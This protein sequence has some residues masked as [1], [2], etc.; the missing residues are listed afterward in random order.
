[1]STLVAFFSRSGHTRDLAGILAERLSADL[2]T[3]T[4]L[5][6]SRLGRRGYLRSSVDAILQNA[7]AIRAP[8]HDP[9]SYDLVIIGTPVWWMGVSPPVRT[10]LLTHRGRLRDVAFFG[11]CG[12]RG[13]DRAFRQMSE[14]CGLPPRATF[15]ARER[16]LG[17]GIR[18]VDVA[19]FVEKLQPIA[20][21]RGNG[22][23]RASS[24]GFTR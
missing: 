9:A 11:T 8:M 6:P 20:A 18:V 15:W 22:H 10:F 23:S 2:D 3:I 16:D 1:M 21:S 4:E 19:R 12:G 7:P 24:P 5:G 14:L 17:P 13:A